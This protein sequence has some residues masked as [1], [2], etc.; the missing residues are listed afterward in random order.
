L[1]AANGLKKGNNMRKTIVSNY[2]TINGF[3]SGPNGEIDRFV[4]AVHCRRSSL[5]VVLTQH[6]AKNEGSDYV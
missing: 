1:L 6:F 4:W 2:I 3:F 5:G